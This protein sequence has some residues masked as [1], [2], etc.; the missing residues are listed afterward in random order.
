MIQIDDTLFLRSFE[1]FE[2]VILP[3]LNKQR[4][5]DGLSVLKDPDDITNAFL[6]MRE[7]YGIKGDGIQS[8][9]TTK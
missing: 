6:E 4:E 7:R 5:I 1:M 9:G 2:R 8:Q 3:L